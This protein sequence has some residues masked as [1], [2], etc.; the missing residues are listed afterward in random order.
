MMYKKEKVDNVLQYR[1]NRLFKKHVE[2]YEL[3]E[4]N[5]IIKD[6]IGS[7]AIKTLN[8]RVKFYYCPQ[9]D[10]K[11]QKLLKN[12]KIYDIGRPIGDILEELIKEGIKVHLHG[13][14]VR[15]VILNL[16]CIDI[17]VSFD[18][19]IYKIEKICIAQ[20]WAC[21][22][23][24]ENENFYRDI[25]RNHYV[26]FGKDKGIT[27]EGSNWKS[28]YLQPYYLYDFS[29]NNMAYDF[30]NKILIDVSGYGLMDL[31]I[32]RFRISPF[33]NEYE[34]WAN[35]DW[36]KPLRYFKMLMKGF[37][38]LH[39]NL[40]NF[41][42]NYIEVNYDVVYNKVIYSKGSKAIT[43]ILHFLIY[44]I[45]QGE[46]TEDGK[47][48][49]GVN[50]NKLI[51]FLKQMALFL[52]YET[53]S[54]ILYSLENENI[55]NQIQVKKITSIAILSKTKKTQLIKQITTELSAKL[56]KTHLKHTKKTNTTTIAATQ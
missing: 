46:F 29:I 11:I 7:Y 10:N 55:I 31:L 24:R 9:I 50:E 18:A 33:P 23:M 38:P 39:S 43:R 35:Y 42:I 15:D 30:K 19:D 40:H 16:K 12:Y 28:T 52:N 49:L 1:I 26:N 56:I 20:K 44:G 54:K 47:Y 4:K 41:I 25:V 27:L 51:P 17:D 53:I 37:K 36:K 14:I 13:G 22:N 5:K 8:R 34:Q 2:I 32:Y 48:I 45:T 3:P 6:I 21:A